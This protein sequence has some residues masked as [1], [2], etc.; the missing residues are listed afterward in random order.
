ME[1]AKFRPGFGFSSFV[2]MELKFIFGSPPGRCRHQ[3]LLP[4]NRLRAGRALHGEN[5][6]MTIP[7]ILIPGT[8]LI[9]GFAPAAP[10]G[11]PELDSKS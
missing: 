2:P 1:F 10:H 3:E 6:G 7:E 5:A 9:P 4:E 8:S 11:A